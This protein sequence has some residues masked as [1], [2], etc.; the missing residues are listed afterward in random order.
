MQPTVGVYGC[1]RGF[2]VVEVAL[3]QVV[4]AHQQLSGFAGRHRVAGGVHAAHFHVREGATG[5]GG[6]DLRRITGAA[7]GDEAAGFGQAVGG[8]YGL[9][10]QLAGH[11]PDHFHRHRGGARHR[12]PQ[13]GKVVALTV[14]EAEDGLVQGRRA[15]QHSDPFAGD[16]LQHHRHV[17][18]LLRQDAAAAHQRRQPTGLVAEAV[19]ERVDDQVAVALTQ[20]DHGTPVAD[21]AQVLAMGSHHALRLAGGARGEQQ[22]GQAVLVDLRLAHRQ[23]RWRDFGAQGHERIPVQAALRLPTQADAPAQFRQRLT[24]QQRRV[25]GAEELADDEQE[26]GAAL[27]QDEAGFGPLHP[28][29]QRHQHRAYALQGDGGD[30]PLMDVRRPDGHPLARPDFQRQQGAG[31]LAAQLVELVVADAG[32]LVLDGH[33]LA[34]AGRGGGQ[35][36]RDGQGAF[37]VGHGLFS[38]ARIQRP[39]GTG[40]GNG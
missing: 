6:H 40:R 8:D 5:G 26:A 14:G 15:R 25:V 11:A 30:Y 20:A 16:A 37:Q 17:E 31:G 34:V 12:H 35:Q 19:E 4:A 27:A 32:A 24:G 38:G 2:R 39:E 1:C 33:G 22:V 36:F 18:H 13:A 29:V 3:H 23:L 28:R 7:D 21:D 9:E 10:T